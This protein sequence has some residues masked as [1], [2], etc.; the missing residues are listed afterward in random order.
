MQDKYF[1]N[2]S[3]RSSIPVYTRRRERERDVLQAMF[4]ESKLELLQ[5]ILIE[6]AVL[7]VQSRCLRKQV[8]LLQLAELA[9][10]L[11]S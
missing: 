5:G 7:V 3:L 2:Y 10:V 11:N 8:I 9:V 6:N 4:E 1:I